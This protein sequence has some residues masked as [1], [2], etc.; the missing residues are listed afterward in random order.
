MSGLRSIHRPTNQIFA[1]R[2]P[3]SIHA[4]LI[5]R[6]IFNFRLPP[7]ALAEKLPV[8][9]LEPQIINDSCIMSFCILSLDGMTLAPLPG[10]LGYKTFSCA[11]RFGVIDI[12]GDR[13]KPAVYV[14]DRSTDLPQMA[15]LAPRVVASSISQVHVN[16]PPGTEESNR[17]ISILSLDLTPIFSATAKRSRQ[18]KFES[19][20]FESLDSCVE[21]I[22]GGVSSYA[23][24]LTNHELSKV[25]LHKNDLAY[26]PLRATIGFDHLESAWPDANLQFDGA[27]WTSGG[28]YHWTY[29]GCR[30]A[31]Q[32]SSIPVTSVAAEDQR[33]SPLSTSPATR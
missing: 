19:Q 29:R 20:V 24:S 2:L 12:S 31:Q 22:R 15:R 18:A 4:S 3:H 32:A 11:H 14:L 27:I 1:M 26:E 10:F 13:P 9:W 30:P 7:E 28:K 17:D 6:F 25:D 23:P 21:F 33:P 5:E 16:I 8:P